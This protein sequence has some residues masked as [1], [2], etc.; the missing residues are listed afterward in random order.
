MKKSRKKGQTKLVCARI[1]GP[2]YLPDNLT[3]KCAECG[4]RVQ[5]RPHA[6]K[7]AIRVCMECW[8]DTLSPDDNPEV[9]VTKRSLDDLRT[10]LRKQKH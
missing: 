10:W 8:S 6:P 5:Y 9:T 7:R 2:L 4:Y 1:N 3:G